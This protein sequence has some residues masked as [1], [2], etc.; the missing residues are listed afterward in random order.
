MSPAAPSRRFSSP[1]AEQPTAAGAARAL[2][3]RR[4]GLRR[5]A[6]PL[7]WAAAATATTAAAA[8]PDD[9]RSGDRP[10]PGRLPG[11][12]GVSK[13]QWEKHR[14]GARRL[15]RMS[16]GA[17]GCSCIN[18]VSE[19]FLNITNTT[20]GPRIIMPY[21]D[22]RHGGLVLQD[23][24]ALAPDYG[25]SCR[26][27]D[28]ASSEYGP[29]IYSSCQ[30]DGTAAGWCHKTWCYVDPCA[31][32]LED[33][34]QTT[35]FNLPHKLPEALAYSYATC[36]QCESQGDQASCL[37][38]TT[39]EWQQDVQTYE[40]R[41]VGSP[42]CVYGLVDTYSS[43]FCASLTYS[44]CIEMFGSCKWIFSDGFG[45]CEQKKKAERIR[46]WS[47]DRLIGGGSSCRCK[48]ILNVTVPETNGAIHY[49]TPQTEF[50]LPSEYGSYCKAW[51]I[52][53][54]LNGQIFL[55]AC[56]ESNRAFN[57]WCSE[58]W[59]FVDPC[60]CDMP[61]VAQSN[62]FSDQYPSSRGR[63]AFSYL[64]C[65]Q[66]WRRKT[67][68]E[69]TQ[70]VQCRWVESGN[71]AMCMPVSDEPY[72]TDEVCSKTEYSACGG[73]RQ[74]NCYQDPTDQTC[75]QKSPY[76]R[77]VA[78]GCEYFRSGMPGCECIQL[79]TKS[80]TTDEY[81]NILVPEL[82]DFAY[83]AQ[84]AANTNTG[85]L[86]VIVRN[87]FG[88]FCNAWD[89]PENS[90]PRLYSGACDGKT[91]ADSC[92]DSWCYVDQCTCN[93]PDA[94][95]SLFFYSQLPQLAYSWQTCAQCTTRPPEVCTEHSSCTLANGECR[96]DGMD[97]SL[98]K[99]CQK[100]D[101]ASCTDLINLT[102]EVKDDTCTVR[103]T[104]GRLAAFGCTSTTTTTTTRIRRIASTSSFS[105]VVSHALRQALLH[106]CLVGFAAVALSI[107]AL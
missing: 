51:D 59:C 43:G 56:A 58:E 64:S 75:K 62:M 10:W 23:E 77:S 95:Q 27:W 44:R 17:H 66:C 74:L 38:H 89:L 1:G 103:D 32:N 26:T 57:P 40:G 16:Q 8:V 106:W 85:P 49:S 11:G 98:L 101:V 29:S 15:F 48:G 93:L 53:E 81:G 78:W 96:I 7:L 36:A 14:C 12:G 105:N 99:F 54:S 39:C 79:D 22:V 107:R 18:P 71:N 45:M 20:D 104:E 50:D 88:S 68:A 69:C 24:Y 102:C 28:L 73:L 46:S 86:N 4:R 13:E 52:P 5:R 80:L 21:D 3:L 9:A 61:D 35:M 91:P 72:F 94:A 100:I 19:K 37:A 76:D 70:T 65:A 42:H 82:P 33:V 31:C 83:T 6:A 92:F 25:S 63:L 84:G 41:P 67:Q 97:I 87:S 34:T 55:T 90:D 47:C 2:L 60:S 30:D